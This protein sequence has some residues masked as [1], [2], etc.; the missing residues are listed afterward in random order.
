VNTASATKKQFQSITQSMKD[1]A[2]EPNELLKWFRQTATSYAAFIPGAKS[3]VDAVFND[4]DTIEQKHRGEVNEI[5]SKAYSDLKSATKNGLS[6][7][8]AQQTW[9]IL[10]KY[11]GQLAD[12]ASDSASEI[13]DN[14]PQLKEKVG[15]NIDQL[16]NMANSYGPDA[17]KELDQTYSQIKEVIAG[18][19]G[20]GTIEKI[21]QI[22]Q[23][24]TEKVKKL[25]DEAWKKGLEQA[26]PYLDK[27]PKIKEQIEKNAD[28]LKSGNI[29]EL[30]EKVKEGNSENI[31]AYIKE[32]AEKAK[33]G[34]KGMGK[35]FEKYVKL[36]PGGDK[37]VPKL[38]QLQEV[39]QKHG[40]DAEK[41]LKE[42]YEEI[43]NVLQKKIGEAEKLADSAKK[44][45]K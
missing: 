30:Y 8:T 25:G 23:E 11:L 14:H 29:S 15:G 13:L 10:Q 21:R 43:A 37:I 40:D 35:D 27:N 26:K 44:D 18:G 3:Y 1:K 20:V 24:K 38:T 33:S 2:P 6:I 22:V 19:V 42:T 32:A 36:I 31:E 9:E 34:G 41:L 16:K 28:A 17:K 39:A 7:E 12:L 4:L 5:V 45:A